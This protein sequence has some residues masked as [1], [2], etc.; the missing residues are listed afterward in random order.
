MI[1][2]PL[3]LNYHP[4]SCLKIDENKTF[5]VY[6]TAQSH[7]QRTLQTTFG[8]LIFCFQLKDEISKKFSTTVEQLC[9]I[10]AGKILKDND[11]LEQNS[12]YSDFQY[13][14]RFPRFQMAYFT[15]A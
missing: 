12:K 13:V 5:N 10:F 11:T 6:V 3:S 4:F 8:F 2:I 14:S 1:L 9:L 7:T 15:E